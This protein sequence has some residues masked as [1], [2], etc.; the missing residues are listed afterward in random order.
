[1]VSCAKLEW[2]S[3]ECAPHHSRS[4]TIIHLCA[5]HHQ[6]CLQAI[7]SSPASIATSAVMEEP[8]PVTPLRVLCSW[9][10]LGPRP[11]RRRGTCGAAQH[12]VAAH[13]GAPGGALRA[14]ATGRH[15]QKVFSTRPGRDG[16][17]CHCEACVQ[18]RH[19]LTAACTRGGAMHA[20]QAISELIS[21][22][23]AVFVCCCGAPT[24][25]AA[26]NTSAH[27]TWPP[28]SHIAC[29]LKKTPALPCL[30]AA[31]ALLLQAHTQPG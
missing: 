19:G 22:L 30:L 24:H 7:T 16:A 14:P 29:K 11:R 20:G 15:A 13:Q 2:P 18:K 4:Y 12:T 25:A 31:R 28:G 26:P 23:D 10:G 8:L 5:G 27:V 1:M 17:W 3:C 6:G 21:S 9:P